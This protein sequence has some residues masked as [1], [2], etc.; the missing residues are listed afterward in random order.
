M[1]I[2][3]KDIAKM[4]NVSETTVSLVLNNRPSRISV[5][6]KEEIKALAKKY[7]YRPNVSARGLASKK[8]NMIGLVIPDI[9]NYFFSQLAKNIDYLL[10]KHGCYLILTI[11]DDSQDNEFQLIDQLV[12]I[13]VDGLLITLSNESYK[14]KERTIDKLNELSVPFVLM[15]RNLPEIECK[16]V[17]YDNVLGGYMATK[18]LLDA[19]HRNIGFIKASSDIENANDRWLGYKKAMEEHHISIEPSWVATGNYRIDGGY[20]AG[21]TLLTNKDLTAV[22]IANDMMALG[23][24]KR[25]KEKNLSIPQDV[26]IVGY[27]YSK[28]I[29]AMVMPL[30]SIVQDSSKLASEAIEL[31]FDKQTRSSERR[32]LTPEKF[33]G[34]SVRNI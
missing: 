1:K 4:A 10:R 3:L 12:N 18:M 30:S 5:A 15:D 11:S 9:E 25:M 8:T 2:K 32:I 33:E 29:E 26:S 22:A 23:F 6:K 7:H 14:D 31:L 34:E 19:G 27:D 13:G 24:I 17:Y 16:Q 20:D 28:I 21:K